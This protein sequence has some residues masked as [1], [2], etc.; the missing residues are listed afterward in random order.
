MLQA[1]DEDQKKAIT[2]A[3]VRGDT[4]RFKLDESSG[5]ITTV[6]GLDYEKQ[7]SYTLVVSTREASGQSDPEYSCTVSITVLV[8]WGCC[9]L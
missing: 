9:I 1:I 8:S 5:R 3:I 4:G 7:D 2:Y 6:Q